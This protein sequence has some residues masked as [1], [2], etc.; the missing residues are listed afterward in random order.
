MEKRK[1]TIV[2]IAVISAL[3]FLGG[4]ALAYDQGGKRGD[5]GSRQGYG[6]R[7]DLTSEQEEKLQVEQER[8]FHDTADMRRELR[9][10]R[11]EMEALWLDPKND[12]EKIKAKHKE[13]LELQ[14]QFQ[15]KRLDH[16]LALREILPEE[17]L[18]QRGWGRSDYGHGPRHGRKHAWGSGYGRE[19][20]R[21]G[22]C[23]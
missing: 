11:L 9:Q 22:F 4:W 17:S 3:V 20:G 19:G 5:R 12:P 2:T 14:R 8:F 23:W 6:C 7:V 16:K 18:G 1:H 15:E 10:K 13:V 21:R